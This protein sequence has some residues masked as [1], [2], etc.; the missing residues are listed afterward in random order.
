M[1]AKVVPRAIVFT[2][3]APVEQA[4]IGALC[5]RLRTTVAR[6]GAKVVICDVQHLTP[7]DA[8][9]VD[10]LAR[11]QLTAR[12]I[13]SQILLVNAAREL[14]ELLDLMGLS[15]VV[16]PYQESLLE[17]KRQPEQGEEPRG[18]E[19]EADPRDPTI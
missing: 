14:S 15:E 3:T 19:E 4:C 7:A 13:G 18:V 17:T 2:I 1:G 11:L 10:L 6:D 8:V 5:D 12:R 9:A 16:P